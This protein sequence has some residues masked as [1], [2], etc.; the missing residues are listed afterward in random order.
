MPFL[1]ITRR[2]NKDFS[3][4]ITHGGDKTRRKKTASYFQYEDNNEKKRPAEADVIKEK[5]WNTV[6]ASKVYNG[7]NGDVMIFI[8]TRPK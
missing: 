6:K 5:I 8:H 4:D 7:H 1:I 2:T 3:R